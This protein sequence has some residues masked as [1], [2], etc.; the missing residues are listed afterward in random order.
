MSKED[1]GKVRLERKNKRNR[2]GG[3]DTTD[4][5]TKYKTE[6]SQMK[7]A[8]QKKNRTI[9]SLKKNNEKENADGNNEEGDDDA[10]KSFGGHQEKKR[11]TKD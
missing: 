4:R 10:G 3:G 5:S 6:L 8:L 7:S 2:K 11:S 1:K 9:S